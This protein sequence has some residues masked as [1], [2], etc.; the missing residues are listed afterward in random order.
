MMLFGL[1]FAILL[2]L[3]FGR[4][5][6]PALM[7]VAVVVAMPF[8]VG[9][10][11]LWGL[12]VGTT[13]RAKAAAVPAPAARPAPPPHMSTTAPAT[14]IRSAKVIDIQSIKNNLKKH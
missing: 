14:P 5:L 2:G 8:W 13:G 3:L 1:A 9:L 11:F 4:L 7:A 10:C 12:V 6:I